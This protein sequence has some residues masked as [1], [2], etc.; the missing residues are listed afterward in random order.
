MTMPGVHSHSSGPRDHGQHDPSQ[1]RDPGQPGS[2]GQPDWPIGPRW[3]AGPQPQ[4]R[5]DP[6]SPTRVWLDPHAAWQGRLYER[7]LEKRIVLASGILDD[8]AATRLSAQ[9]LTLDAEGTG[10]DEPIRLELQNI[11]ADLAAALTVMGVLDVVRVPVHAHASGE[12]GGAALG[13]LAACPRRL[14]YPNATF[15]LSEPKMEFGGT[16]AAVSAREQQARRMLDTLY[17][18]L[19]EVT[20]REVDDIRE[21]ARRGRSLTA[22]E[23]IGYGLIQDRATPRDA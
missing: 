21:D 11:R 22:A 12:I 19:A 3:P 17:Y 6:V 1:G 4:P 8:E 18:R 10:K 20:G 16:V 7:L 9:L 13:V 14:A 2:P 23:A 15:T 5:Q